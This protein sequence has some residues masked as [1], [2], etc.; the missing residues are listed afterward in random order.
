MLLKEFEVCKYISTCPFND[1]TGQNFCLGAS[2]QRPGIF[3]CT[4]VSDEGIFVESGFRSK[5][6]ENGKMKVIME[7]K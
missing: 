1:G 6:D 3:N 7:N 4:L 5:H 2:S